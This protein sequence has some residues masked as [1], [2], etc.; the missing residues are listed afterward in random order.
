MGTGT[1]ETNSLSALCVST[2][3]NSIEVQVPGKNTQIQN[4][5]K[6]NIELKIFGEIYQNSKY[7]ILKI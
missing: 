1:K 3:K 5:R 2:S 6:R 7:L 4:I